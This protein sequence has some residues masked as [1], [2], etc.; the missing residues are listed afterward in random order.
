MTEPDAT[1][2]MCRECGAENAGAA[3][4]CARC[5][6]HLAPQ[7]PA[8]AGTAGEARGSVS[9]PDE[10]AGRRNR[11]G[12]RRRALLVTGLGFVLLVAVAVL[13]ASVTMIVT[14]SASSRPS[15]SSA[16]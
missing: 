9:L 8:A 1:P 11:P 7:P 13:V 6:A 14:R 3:Q 4:G 5:G 10:L 15:A 16:R 12:A 2:Q